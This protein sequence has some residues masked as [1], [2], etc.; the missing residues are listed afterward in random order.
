MTNDPS[1]SAQL[2][3]EAETAYQT[4]LS[5]SIAASNPEAHQRVTSAFE[6]LAESVSRGDATSFAAARAQAWTGILAGSYSIVEEAIQN[7]DGLTAQRWLPLREFRTATRFSRPNVGATV[8]VESFISGDTSAEDALLA[9]RA[10]VL[11]TYQ[12]R[13]TES[14]HDLA[15]A[16]ANGFASRRAELTA[17]AEGYFLI[18]SPAYL[19]QRGDTSLLN[20]QAAFHDLR[21]SAVDNPQQLDEKLAVVENALDNFRAAP[22][23]PAEQSRRAGQLLRF[24]SLVP[25]E[26][27]RGVARRTRHTGY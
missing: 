3:Q 10:D 22:L 21:M 12:A 2:V 11:D 9:V 7:G 15:A 19:E 13:L 27:G 24:L 5:D 4:E 23:S 6:A 8:T 20:A 25:V 17:L 18:L 1:A 26:Y 14:L 16:D